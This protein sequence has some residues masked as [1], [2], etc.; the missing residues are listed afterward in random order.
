[1]RSTNFVSPEAEEKKTS[2]YFRTII[3]VAEYIAF[4]VMLYF[5][6][7]VGLCL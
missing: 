6:A 1:M 5:Y 7:V 2:L 4:A 3:L